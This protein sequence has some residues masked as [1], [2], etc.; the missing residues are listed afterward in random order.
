MDAFLELWRI[1]H[2]GWE[3][4]HAC[5]HETDLFFDG[6]VI[7]QRSL[8]ERLDERYQIRT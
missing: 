3:E 5:A 2:D 4:R 6:A 7:D 8:K 1:V